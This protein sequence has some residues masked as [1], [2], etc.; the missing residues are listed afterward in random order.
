MIIIEADDVFLGFSFSALMLALAKLVCI[1][2]ADMTLFPA[3]SVS[4]SR[5][6]NGCRHRRFS[7]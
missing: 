1:A 5:C 4:H 2:V 7:R 6:I 3:A